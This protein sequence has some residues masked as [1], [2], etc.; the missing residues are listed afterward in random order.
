MWRHEQGSKCDIIKWPY[1]HGVISLRFI[2]S[3]WCNRYGWLGVKNQCL[4]NYPLNSLVRRKQHGGILRKKVRFE[5][6]QYFCCITVDR[7][8]TQ[9]W[10]LQI[11][12]CTFRAFSDALSLRSPLRLSSVWSL[13]QQQ[14]LWQR[15]YVPTAG[16]VDAP[17]W[18]VDLKPLLNWANICFAEHSSE[19]S[20]N[21]T[22]FVNWVHSSLNVVMT[23]R[24]TIFRS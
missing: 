10:Q 5:A 14:I 21:F 6:K 2:G 7:T 13:A 18:S 22:S 9:S 12:V 1:V 8:T 3:P 17:V 19:Y 23:V 24:Q 15:C 4:C 16:S 11:T 20:S